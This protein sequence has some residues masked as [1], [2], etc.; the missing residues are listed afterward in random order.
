MIFGQAVADLL[1]QL[2]RSEDE[3]EPE[4]DDDA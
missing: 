2:A 1:G 3:G 4:E